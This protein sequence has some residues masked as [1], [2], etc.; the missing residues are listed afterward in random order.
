M[1]TTTIRIE[2]IL[3]TIKET[4]NQKGSISR[5]VV[6]KKSNINDPK[7]SDTNNYIFSFPELLKKYKT[8][9]SLVLHVLPSDSVTFVFSLP[10]IK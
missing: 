8:E 7:Q 2:D 10:K 1:N 6:I 3:F 4:I 9:G 5:E